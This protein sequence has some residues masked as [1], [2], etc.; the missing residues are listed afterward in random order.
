MRVLALLPILMIITVPLAYAESEGCWFIFCLFESLFNSNS[1]EAAEKVEPLKSEPKNDVKIPRIG[2]QE[3][4]DIREILDAYDKYALTEGEGNDYLMELL[5]SDR[6]RML[7]VAVYDWLHEFEK[8]YGDKSVQVSPGRFQVEGMTQD[9]YYEHNLITKLNWLVCQGDQRAEDIK[10]YSKVYHDSLTPEQIAGMQYSD[11][12]DNS[13]F[14][15]DGT[16]CEKDR[17][18]LEERDKCVTKNKFI[19][20][21]CGS[22][23]DRDLLSVCTGGN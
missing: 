14:K 17:Y 13:R 2:I 15:P 5:H 18:W 16:S 9:Q 7:C 4:L 11:A 8:K 12:I 20:E 22:F 1:V 10:Q 23:S 6:T 3:I 21:F 19:R